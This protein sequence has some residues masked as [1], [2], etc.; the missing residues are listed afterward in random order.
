MEAKCKELKVSPRCVPLE[1][2]PE[3]GKCL[4][5]G[6]PSTGRAVFARSY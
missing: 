1:A 4:F 5:S 2:D 6:E 3:P